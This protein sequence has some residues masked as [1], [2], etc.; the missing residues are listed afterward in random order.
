MDE[1]M[2]AEKRIEDVKRLSE[3]F[4]T[5][6]ALERAIVIG[7]TKGIKVRSDMDEEHKKA[8]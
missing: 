8:G 5:L 1:T 3:L 6:P 2:N 4:F 7:F